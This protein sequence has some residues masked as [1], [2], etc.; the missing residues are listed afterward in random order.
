[1]LAAG[2]EGIE[3]GMEPPPPVDKNI[4]TLSYRERRRLRIDS[5]PGNLGEAVAVAKKSKFLKKVLGEHIFSQ[6]I[7]A[8][9]EEWRDY[10]ARV[11]TWELDRYLATY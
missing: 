1:M 7:Q 6:Y 8:K 11:H 4:F 3:Q 5:L 10:I 2:I 9:G